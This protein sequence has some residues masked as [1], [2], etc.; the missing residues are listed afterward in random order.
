MGTLVGLGMSAST[1]LSLAIPRK[2]MDSQTPGPFSYP[3]SSLFSFILA[4]SFSPSISP[5][6][7]ALFVFLLPF[8]PL[9]AAIPHSSFWKLLLHSPFL[10]VH[11]RLA[12][13][14][15]TFLDGKQHASNDQSRPSSFATGVFVLQSKRGATTWPVPSTLWVE[16]EQALK[17]ELHASSNGASIAQWEKKAKAAPGRRT[18]SSS[19]LP[20]AKKQHER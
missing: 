20:M 8:F 14:D 10:Q 3:P 18:S 6:S 4:F 11:H 2:S 12:Q 17:A 9:I 7:L 19:G 16:V 15:H 5:S 13:K 1:L